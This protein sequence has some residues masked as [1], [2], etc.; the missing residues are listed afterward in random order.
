MWLLEWTEPALTDSRNPSMLFTDIED[1]TK[2]VSGFNN[3][4]FT[5]SKHRVYTK[6]QKAEGKKDP[7]QGLPEPLSR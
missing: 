3:I 6:P 1:L 2:Y 7:L 4:K 5:I